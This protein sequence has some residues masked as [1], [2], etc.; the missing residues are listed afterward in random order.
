MDIMTQ[1]GKSAYL[2]LSSLFFGLNIVVAFIIFQDWP[3]WSLTRP[4]KAIIGALAAVTLNL[5]GAY[6]LARYLRSMNGKGG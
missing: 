2:L 6:W 5:A 3:E 4:E 1:R